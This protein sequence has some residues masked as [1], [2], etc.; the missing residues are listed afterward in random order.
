MTHIYDLNKKPGDYLPGLFISQHLAKLLSR[1]VALHSTNIVSD[2]VRALAVTS[3]GPIPLLWVSMAVQSVE[4]NPCL[5]DIELY[6]LR[7]L[8]DQHMAYQEPLLRGAA[9][10]CLLR[11][12]LA[13]VDPQVGVK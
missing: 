5:S 1:V 3:W 12:C 13:L 9:Q 10:T 11:S 4:S 8:V 7:L 2:F 6:Q